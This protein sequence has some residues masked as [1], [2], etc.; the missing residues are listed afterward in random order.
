MPSG[1]EIARGD[2]LSPDT[3]SDFFA[4]DAE[5]IV[6]HAAA[7]ISVRRRDAA[8]ERINVEGTKN[9]LAACRQYGI[10]RLIHFS[11]VDALPFRS[12]GS[13]AGE[14]DRF[15]PERLP[16]SYG[17]SK[18]EASQLVLDAMK[19]GLE[20]VLLMP[21]C[22]IGPGDYRKGFVSIM[23]GLYLRGLPRLSVRGGYEF[24]DVR[25]VAAAAITAARGAGSGCYLLS[26][27]YA[28]MTFV[29]DTM[30]EKTGRKKTLL[31]L[32]LWVLYPL[33][34][35]MSAGY[36]LAGRQP[37]LTV[38]AVR[39]LGAR[40]NYDAGRAR[41]ELDFSPRPLSDTIADTVDFMQRTSGGESL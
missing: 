20:A 38:F 17:R 8:I 40:P 41:R 19:D 33:A 14:P 6:I 12:D 11:S 3:L 22:V 36:L 25:D 30:A 10:Q 2:L 15:F 32:P 39:L 9:I 37:P 34:P 24:V 35:L 16:T 7:A 4:G 27:G 5:K 29:L 28:N 21:A 23:L 1:V 13:P 18:A 31:T 26:G